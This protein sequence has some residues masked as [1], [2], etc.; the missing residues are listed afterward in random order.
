M[1]G[2][3]RWRI[4]RLSLFVL[5]LLARPDAGCA[6]VSAAV[7]GRVE[8][9]S[10]AAV[11]GATVTVK[12]VETGARRVVTTDPTGN[13]R[14]LSV[15]VGL[16]E[17]KAEREGFRA[18]VQTGIKLDVGVEAVVNFRLAVGKAVEEISVSEDIPMVNTT[19]ASVAGLVG[20]REVKDLPLNG[21]SFD[22]LIT[23]NPGAI[24]YT[25]MRSP[26][27]TTSNGNAFAVDGQKPGDNETLLNGVEYTG[28]S[29]L[30]VTPGGVSGYLLGIDAV[31]EFNLQTST[32]GAEY[33][34]RSGAQ[35]S[36]VTQSGSNALHGTLYE[37]LREQRS[38]YA[39]LF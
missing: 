35:V 39:Q 37:F 9:A 28:S 8:D 26:N 7:S 25:D 36:V 24:N 11:S 30:A 22:D 18:A 32:Y 23:L 3:T 6:Q 20:E 34:K 33:G 29:Q 15:S 14:V 13:Y 19:T 4:W 1:S 27:T 17:I 16:H 31:R 5:A 12:D 21:R 38:G 10:G 2:F